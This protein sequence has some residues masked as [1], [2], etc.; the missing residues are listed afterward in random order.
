MV[1]L[2]FT[3]F[4]VFTLTACQT[5]TQSNSPAQY[6]IKTMVEEFTQNFCKV[7]NKPNIRSSNARATQLQYASDGSPWVRGFIQDDIA[8]VRGYTQY[9]LKTGKGQCG[10]N[11]MRSVNGEI[12][13]WR[14]LTE[15]VAEQLLLTSVTD[16]SYNKRATNLSKRKAQIE[17]EVAQNGERLSELGLTY[18]EKLDLAKA[19]L[20]RDLAAIEELEKAP[21]TIS[22]KSTVS[23]QGSWNVVVSCTGR[24]P[25][26]GSAVIFERKS[27][28]V[29]IDNGD[30]YTGKIYL[31]DQSGDESSVYIDLIAHPS[32]SEHR[33]SIQISDAS[34][35][36]NGTS[37]SSKID[38]TC[39]FN[40]LKSSV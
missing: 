12:V 7:S 2:I 36:G 5:V 26:S 29:L 25:F 33:I 3:C 22:A 34:L 23:L 20:E 40:A 16:R 11:G 1:R 4:A 19:K 39:T 14:S 17:T 37:I 27:A 28:R 6:Q 10:G 15:P 24:K 32:N 30:T 13:S 8:K 9:N 21:P 38:K 35:S 31:K 18:E